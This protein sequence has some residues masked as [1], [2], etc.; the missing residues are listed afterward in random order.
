MDSYLNDIDSDC[1]A[2]MHMYKW[3]L[4]KKKKR[5]QGH[6]NYS[7]VFNS[8]DKNVSFEKVDDLAEANKKQMNADKCMTSRR[9]YSF[10]TG[11]MIVF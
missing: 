2:N 10:C 1:T 6:M 8:R 3:F 4:K 5:H 9:H 11:P 7:E